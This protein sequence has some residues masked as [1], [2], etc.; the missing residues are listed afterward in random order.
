MNTAEVLAQL[1]EER[2]RLDDA[3]AAL[4]GLEAGTTVLVERRTPGR[5]A[6]T[7]A[8]PESTGKRTMSPDA[9]ARIGAAQKARWAKQKKSK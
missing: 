6:K 1:R 7:A 2:Q 5:P 8:I 3:I 9:R 4:E